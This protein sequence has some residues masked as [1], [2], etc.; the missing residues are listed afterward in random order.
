MPASNE[1]FGDTASSGVVV[2]GNTSEVRVIL[3][4]VEKHKGHLLRP[5]PVGQFRGQ[6]HR[7]GDDAIHLIIQNF[8]NDVTDVTLRLGCHE[9]EDMIP[10]LLQPLGQLFQGFRIELIVQIGDDKADDAA[11]PRDHCP[12]KRIGPVAKFFRRFPDFLARL[13]RCR[14]AGSEDAAHR[15]LAYACQPCHVH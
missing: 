1:E 8:L 7:R 14:R 12:G 11:S 2:R 13:R 6:R 9:D 10:S 15:R 3:G 4:P 5:A